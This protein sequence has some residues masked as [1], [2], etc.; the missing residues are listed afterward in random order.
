MD[1]WECRDLGVCKEFLRMAIEYENGVIRVDQTAY[2]LK[3]LERFGMADSKH[4]LTPLPTGYKPEPFDG[5]STP[6]LRSKY[7]SV[8]GSLLYLMLGTRP[9]IAFAVCQMAK[10][11]ANPS[12]E[13]LNKALYIMK[14][15][16]GTRSYAL[17]Y[18]GKPNTGF[19]AYCNLS[20]GDDQSDPPIQTDVG[21]I[22]LRKSTQGYFFS[23]ANACVKWHSSTQKTVAPSSTAAEYMSLA[24]CARDCVWYKNLFS[25]IQRPLQY[26]TVYADAN[27]AIF[28]AQNPVA[29]KGTKHVDIRHH[30]VRDQI[31]QG[32]IQLFRVD[33]TDNPADMFTKNLGPQLF[34]KHRQSLGLKF[35]P[36]SK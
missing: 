10:F 36:L 15:L 29:Q 22:L 6:E 9:D 20:Y 34:L 16:S 27:G 21:P 28:S 24:D 33:S 4:A 18:S 7:Q 11:A 8:I 17:I 13:H 26:V 31:E 5:T 12:V 23:L 25:E 19:Y 2:L 35:Y 32:N 14:Y 3:V 1:R 30:F